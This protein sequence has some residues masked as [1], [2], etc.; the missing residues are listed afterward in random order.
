MIQR[1]LQHNM[2][3]ADEIQTAIPVSWLYVYSAKV[4]SHTTATIA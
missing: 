1:E 4:A 2:Q 3:N